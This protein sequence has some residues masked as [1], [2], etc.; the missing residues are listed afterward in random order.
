MVA[1][2]ALPH[3]GRRVP[4][5]WWQALVGVA[6]PLVRFAGAENA[7]LAPTTP[8]GLRAARGPRGVAEARRVLDTACPVLDAQLAGNAWTAGAASTMADCA[9]VARVIDEA[10]PYRDLFPMAWPADVDRNH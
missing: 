1:L 8:C 9:A 4:V 10:R 2:R 3:I 5:V 6:D 7:R